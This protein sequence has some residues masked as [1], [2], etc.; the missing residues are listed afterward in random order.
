MAIWL[1]RSHLTGLPPA[2]EPVAAY[3]ISEGASVRPLTELHLATGALPFDVGDTFIGDLPFT[4]LVL[5]LL[6]VSSLV[7][8]SY[9]AALR[10]F[11]CRPL[12]HGPA[13]SLFAE[14]PSW[15]L[16]P[17]VDKLLAPYPFSP[18]VYEAPPTDG[19]VWGSP[20]MSVRSEWRV[21][22]LEQERIGAYRYTGDGDIDLSVADCA[23]EAFRDAPAGYCLDFALT[24]AGETVLL[25]AND[26][27]ALANVGLAVEAHVAIHA[28]R[29]AELFKGPVPV[30]ASPLLLELAECSPGD[31]FSGWFRHIAPLRGTDAYPA[32]HG[33]VLRLAEIL[34]ACH[35][36]E[37]V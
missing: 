13:A 2:L 28:A 22:V 24:D 3:L 18:G 10:P 23:I 32:A 17:G 37:A 6:G 16:K 26:G 8:C 31:D 9:P 20:P 11:L 34:V 36:S 5:R 33:L 14:A 25:E 4:R 1:G 35:A 15:F 30:S 27:L 21:Y 12:R 19:L 7:L 29:W